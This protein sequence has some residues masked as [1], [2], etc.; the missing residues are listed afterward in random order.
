MLQRKSPLIFATAIREAFADLADDAQVPISTFASCAF[1]VA[2][3]AFPSIELSFLLSLGLGWERSAE[4]MAEGWSNPVGGLLSFG[5]ALGA[6][7]LVQVNKAH[8]LFCVDQRYLA[9]LPGRKRQGFRE[10]GALAFTTSVGGPLS[11]IVTG[12]FRGGYQEMRARH[13]S[14][15]GEPEGAPNSR[16]WREKRHHLRL[17][18]PAYLRG[19]R[20]AFL[21]EGT[22]QVSIRSCLRALAPAE[23]ARLTFPGIEELV[24][25]D[26]LPDLRQRLRSVVAIVQQESE[27]LTSMFDVFRLLTDEVREIVSLYRQRGG[28]LPQAAALG[29]ERVADRLKE[30][31]RVP[32]VVFCRPTAQD[33]GRELR[34]LPLGELTPAAL[35][36]VELVSADTLQPLPAQPS[37]LPFWNIRAERGAQSSQAGGSLRQVIESVVENGPRSAGELALLRLW[38]MPDPPRPLLERALLAAEGV[39]PEPP[40]AV[41]ALFYLGEVVDSGKE[42]PAGAAHELLGRAAREARAYLEAYESSIGQIGPL[43]LAIAFERPPF[44]TGLDEALQS[45]GRFAQEVARSA[46]EHG[47]VVRAAACAGEGQIFEDAAG[48]PAVVSPA[49]S[50]V[51]EL[52]AAARTAAPGRP[53]FALEGAS[54][55]LVSLLGQRL[56]GWEKAPEG[57]EGAALW[58]GPAV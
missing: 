45:A 5:H 4:R 46:L 23:V 28:L 47:I 32:F 38:F 8:H 22:T 1:G 9:E 33:A 19:M 55:L 25:A 13:R 20:G 16:L 7:G 6:S 36:E 40:P 44:R 42:L 21:I 11:H 49:A 24:Q 10:D 48:R 56:A 15:R 2:H 12:L 43:L 54:S 30:S 3:D 26:K 35:D 53:A 58:I 50:R 31:L 57:P 14:G 17:V 52:L 41:R 18:L 51:Q 39:A 27:R 37:E 34:F 29:E